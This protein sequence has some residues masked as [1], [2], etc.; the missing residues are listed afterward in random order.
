MDSKI[1]NTIEGYL[2]CDDF[3][4]CRMDYITV[5]VFYD[6]RI[7]KIEFCFERNAYCCYEIKYIKS[8]LYR[9]EV[10]HQDFYRDHNETI[11]YTVLSVTKEEAVKI[12]GGIKHA[13]TRKFCV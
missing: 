1:H 5:N 8:G 9:I 6:N 4:Y 12:L 3:T 7:S 13:A 11:L 2:S 10:Y